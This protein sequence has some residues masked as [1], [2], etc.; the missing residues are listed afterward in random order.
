MVQAEG[1]ASQHMGRG[2]EMERLS[3]ADGGLYADHDDTMRVQSD[4]TTILTIKYKGGIILGADSRSSNVSFL[5]TSFGTIILTI[6]LTEKKLNRIC[7]WVTASA[8]SWSRFTIAFTASG[9]A[10]AATPRPLRKWSDTTSTS[11]RTNLEVSHL[12][13]RRRILCGRLFTPMRAC[14]Q[15]A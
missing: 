1:L 14:S 10:R 7:M 13:N 8:T 5:I 11:R 3:V 6:F 15:P 9:R 2:Y 12:W 4:G